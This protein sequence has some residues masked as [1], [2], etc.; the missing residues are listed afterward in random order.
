MHGSL[1]VKKKILFQDSNCKFVKI[2][3]SSFKDTPYFEKTLWGV[4]ED[5]VYI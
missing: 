3:E 5:K 4:G 2:G 1:R